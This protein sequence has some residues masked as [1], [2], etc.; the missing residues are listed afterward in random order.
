MIRFEVNIA[1]AITPSNAPSYL[2]L[3]KRCEISRPG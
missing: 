3:E 2:E 1:R